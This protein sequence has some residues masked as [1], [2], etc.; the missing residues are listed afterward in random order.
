LSLSFGVED[1]VKKL[2]RVKMKT[3]NIFK[4]LKS[5]GLQ[6]VIL[7][8]EKNANDKEDHDND[9]GGGNLLIKSHHSLIRKQR[10]SHRGCGNGSM[11]RCS[12][13]KTKD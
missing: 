12:L 6:G 9:F 4:I 5:S 1:L 8:L 11:P 3:R 13:A 2:V 7:Q 10:V